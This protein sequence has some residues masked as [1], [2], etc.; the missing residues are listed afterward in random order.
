LVDN[1]SAQAMFRNT[2]T[3]RLQAET[4]MMSVQKAS[5]AEVAP[6]G[7]QVLEKDN[8]MTFS[9]APTVRTLCKCGAVVEADR[10]VVRTKRNLGKSVECRRCRTARIATE[11]AELDQEFFGIQ[12][13][14]S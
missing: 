3:F 9:Q 13:D 7:R 14:G 4:D 12:E 11:K 5:M 2:D 6:L 8:Y 1:H 10:N